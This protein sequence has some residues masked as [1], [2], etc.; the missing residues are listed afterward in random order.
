MPT[1]SPLPSHDRS[2]TLPGHLRCGQV[3]MAL[4]SIG[5]TLF[6]ATAPILSVLSATKFFKMFQIPKKVTL[7]LLASLLRVLPLPL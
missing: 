6:V 2:H 1:I 7:E 5:P 3:S 4:P